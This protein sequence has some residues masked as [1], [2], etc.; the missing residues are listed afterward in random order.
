MG[1][2]KRNLFRLKRKKSKLT[3]NLAEE[4]K[5]FQKLV[6]EGIKVYLPPSEAYA[7]RVRKAMEYSLL[8]GGKRI[9][10]ILCLM[11]CKAVGGRPIKALPAACALEYIHTYSLIHDDLPALDNDDYRR[12]HLTCH[13]KFGEATAILAGDALLTEAFSLLSR[14]AVLSQVP[15]RTRLQVIQEMARAAGIQ[16]MVAGQEADL[17]AEKKKVSLNCLQYIHQHKT[18]ALITAS[19]VCGGLIG[20]GTSGEIR[21]LR[22]FGE[23][24]GLAF[25]IKDDLLNVEGQAEIMGKET[26]TDERRAKATYPTLLGLEQSKTKGQ[27]LL[28]EA[29]RAIR[30]LGGKA[31]PLV[32]IGTYILSRD[33]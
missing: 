17:A 12:G 26:G 33:K 7:L 30:I 4:L 28:V 1:A 24:I 31:L 23:K 20:G 11:A 32:Q 8:V 3:N 5:K 29:N 15:A 21:A 13:K 19:L 27:E 9:R 25:Q 10:P 18:G 22:K 14:K 2:S 6:D 16:G